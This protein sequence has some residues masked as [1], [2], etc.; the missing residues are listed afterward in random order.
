MDAFL[1]ETEPG[2]R[3]LSIGAI[4]VGKKTVHIT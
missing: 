4:V 2:G 3:L 1:G